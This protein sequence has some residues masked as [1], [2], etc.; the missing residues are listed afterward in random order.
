MDLVDPHRATNQS[1]LTVGLCHFRLRLGDFSMSTLSSMFL[2]MFVGLLTNTAAPEY[3]QLNCCAKHAYC[4][5]IQS[6][7]CRSVDALQTSN[8]AIA[9]TQDTTAKPVCCIKRAYCC[10]QHQRCCHS[11]RRPEPTGSPAAQAEPA[12]QVVD[13]T[14]WLSRS[15]S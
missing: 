5:T 11:R 4:C 13:R 3:N 15:R 12:N 7:C 6:S 14:N 10:S 2:A 9:V 8:E 1:R